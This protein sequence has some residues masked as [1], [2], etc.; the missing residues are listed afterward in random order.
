MMMMNDI[1]AAV[2]SRRGYRR[3]HRHHEPQQQ[4]G[5][6]DPRSGSP[7]HRRLPLRS[8][9]LQDP[10]RCHRQLVK[11]TLSFIMN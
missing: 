5:E 4:D 3:E 9:H 6:E 2:S 7:V 11:N 8:R 1:G 10:R